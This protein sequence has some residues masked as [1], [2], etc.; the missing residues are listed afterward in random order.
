M[1][2]ANWS[3]IRADYEAG[4]TSLRQLAS[5]HGVSKTYLIERRDKEG[6]N[7]PD[8]PPL[9]RPLTTKQARPDTNLTPEKDLSTKDRQRLFLEAFSEHANVLVS[10]RAAGISRQIVYEWL[11]HDQDFSFAYN[12]A[13][14]DAK[15]VLRAEIFRRAK[16]GWEEPV[17]QL[18]YL[19]GTVRKYS[20]TLLIFHTKALMPEYR[21]KQQVEV[22]GPGG[23]PIQVQH[24]QSLT[25][26]E[27]DALERLVTQVA[28]RSTHGN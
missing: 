19:A 28:E 20:D 23:A 25:N 4:G 1:G 18:G 17:F 22:S 24:L 8:R 6:W 26:E 13:K 12:Q 15:D 27:L 3:T 10:A 7:R 14:E 5:K 21:D 16:E 2:E 9:S 11:E